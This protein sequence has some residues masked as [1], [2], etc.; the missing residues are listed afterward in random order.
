MAK[1]D[2]S[3]GV[4][5]TI[6]GRKVFIKNGQDLASA[7]IE[8][9]KFKKGGMR[10][11]YRKAKEEDEE[12][13][14]QAK[15]QEKDF[16]K[17]AE[18]E[19][20]K[21]H[22]EPNE[23]TIREELKDI[24][25]EKERKDLRG[26]GLTDDEIDKGYKDVNEAVKDKTN[27]EYELYKRA[28]D[29][30][31]SIDPMT[32]NSTDWE[33]LDKK[34]K[35]RYEKEKQQTFTQKTDMYGGTREYSKE[36]LDRMEEHG[37]KPME[38]SYTGGGWEGTKYDSNLSTKDIAKNISDYAKDEFPDVKLSRKTDYNGIDI[39]I[40]SSEK[41]LYKS[42]SDIDN[43]S[44]EQISATIRDSV[45]GYSRFDDWLNDNNK[46][47]ANGT[48]TVNEQKEY[49]KNELQTYKNR[50]GDRVTGSEWYLSDYGQKVVSGL[51]KEMNSYNFDDSD[52][53][54]DYFHTNFYGYVQI[55]KW[56]KPY[57]VTSKQTSGNQITNSLRQRAYNKY[58]KEHPGSEMSFE[59]FLKKQ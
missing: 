35:D 13:K 22:K 48:Y 5:R 46:K 45:G 42:S 59:D 4:W 28:K 25:R 53:M 19:D 41:D 34:F 38:H 3:D 54:V 57:E 40:M 30:P 47:S 8:S 50:K 31:D 10:A 55:G 27:N 37:A 15:E 12:S 26:K 39:N 7:M 1:Y 52:G 16:A 9:G 11:A 56:D 58:I 49:L 43:M 33:E 6:G 51:N 29:N 21:I 18:K 32:E 23:R 17:Q 36:E 14:K 20:K 24:E 2:E 44:N